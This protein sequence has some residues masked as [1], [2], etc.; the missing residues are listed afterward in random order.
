M[1]PAASL[2][3]RWRLLAR[4]WRGTIVAA[5]LGGVLVNLLDISIDWYHQ[6]ALLEQERIPFD[7]WSPLMSA[8]WR[9][10]DALISMLQGQAVYPYRFTGLDL[11]YGRPPTITLDVWWNY[12]WLGGHGRFWVVAGVAAAL[13]VLVWVL[14]RL[15]QATGVLEVSS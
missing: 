5:A 10:G 8:I 3:A 7:Y 4:V 11:F 14:A 12:A 13:L 15:V 2:I 1:L 6:L 9:H